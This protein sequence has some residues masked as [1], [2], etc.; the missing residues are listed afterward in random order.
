MDVAVA[1]GQSAALLTWCRVNERR[2][3]VTI[4]EFLILRMGS[5]PLLCFSAACHEFAVEM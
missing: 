4:A 1:G 5:Y 3:T 2:A